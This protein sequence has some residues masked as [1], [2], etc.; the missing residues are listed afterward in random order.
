MRSWVRV[1]VGLPAPSQVVS[2]ATVTFACSDVSLEVGSGGPG[3]VLD[4]RGN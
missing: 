2:A 4:I 3:S 1:T